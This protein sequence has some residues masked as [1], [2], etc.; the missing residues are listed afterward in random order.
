MT[1]PPQQPAVTVTQILDALAE[2][3][4]EL[5]ATKDEITRLRKFGK[6]NRA[7]IL[8]DVALTIL[9]TVFGYLSVHA[10]QSANSAKAGQLALCQAGNTARAQQVQLW[11]HLID[12]PPAPGTPK[13]TP[14]QQKQL[15]DF[16]AYVVHVFAPRDCARITEGHTADR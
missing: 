11:T 9:L 13:R 15:D 4:G 1:T 16:R 10:T 7:F 8:V 12:T 2:T 5:A 6:H 14:T 3:R